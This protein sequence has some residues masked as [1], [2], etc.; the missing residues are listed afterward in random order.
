MLNGGTLTIAGEHP[1]ATFAGV[2]TG[3]GSLTNAGTLRLV[4]DASIAL[5]GTF[6]NTGIL[7]LMTWSGTLPNGFINSGIVLDRSKVCVA[8]YTKSGNDFSL[9]VEGYRGHSY[10]LVSGEFDLTKLGATLRPC[11]GRGFG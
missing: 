7:D 5:S 6:T 1:S 4:G 10:Q 9:T 11:Q 2:I 3:I 8:S